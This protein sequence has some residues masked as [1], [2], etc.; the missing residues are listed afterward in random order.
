MKEIA[1]IIIKMAT[2]TRFT[3]PYKLYN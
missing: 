1:K 2:K 3:V